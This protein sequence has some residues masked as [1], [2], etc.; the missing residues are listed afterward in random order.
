MNLQYLITSTIVAVFI[1][2]NAQPSHAEKLFAGFYDW[3]PYTCNPDKTNGNKGYIVEIIEAAYNES[4]FKVELSYKPYARLL[5]ELKHGRID[6]IAGATREESTPFLVPTLNQGFS[7]SSFFSF[8]PSI[9]LT[10]PRIIK[11]SSKIA[12]VNGYEYNSPLFDQI[13]KTAADRIFSISGDGAYE[14][15]FTL[16]TLGRLDFVHDDI[17]AMRYYIDQLGYSG[18][19]NQS[20]EN[21]PHTP[22]YIPFSA[23]SI[24]AQR[25]L[26]WFNEIYPSLIKSGKID[27]ILSKYEISS[28]EFDYTQY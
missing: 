12:I 9:S 22:I 20:H 3:C 21:D 4:E 28:E 13:K 8:H 2:L 24:S 15:I 1:L 17:R 23:K 26:E 27:R 11:T 25:A 14:R 7:V 19:V 6:I 16:L 10:Q 5:L 18:L